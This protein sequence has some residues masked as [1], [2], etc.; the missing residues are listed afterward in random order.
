MPQKST[1]SLSPIDKK[2]AIL[3]AVI[4]SAY[5][6]PPLIIIFLIAEFGVN[7]PHWDQWALV[8]LFLKIK[9][10]SVSF[11]DFFAQHNEHRM[12]FSRIIIV[13]LAF[14]SNWNNK[15]EMYFGLFLGVITF[16]I[17]YLISLKSISFGKSQNLS[18]FHLGNILTCFIFFSTSQLENYLW[19]F[20]IAWFLVNFC[21]IAA[22][23]CLVLPSGKRYGY[24]VFYAGLLC[25]IASFTHGQGLLTWIALLPLLAFS[26][27]SLRKRTIV[28]ALWITAFLTTFFIYRIGYIT[29]EHHAELS[30]NSQNFTASFKYFLTLL[31][32][33]FS[34][35]ASPIFLTGLFLLS[36]FLIFN[37][38]FL[39]NPYSFSSQLICPWLPLGWF[40]ILFTII[41]TSGRAGLGV[42][43][44]ASS[45]YV[46]VTMLLMIALI[47]MGRIFL[48]FDKRRNFGPL[49]GA[50]G[51]GA[52]LSIQL[53]TTSQHIH[54]LKTSF[55]IKE[56][57]KIC[58]ELSRFLL[59]VQPND[60]FIKCISIAVPD[61]NYVFQNFD[62]LEN[63]GF[64][65][66]P[67]PDEITFE[68]D[69]DALEGYIDSPEDSNDPIVISNEQGPLVITGWSVLSNHK[70]S[71]SV[72]ILSFKSDG[73]NDTTLLAPKTVIRQP[74]PDVV[75]V[76][77][78]DKVLQS[79]WQ[80][81]I[82]PQVIPQG[83][84]VLKIWVYE[85]ES[86]RFLGLPETLRINKVS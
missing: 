13:I 56:E 9:D 79:G 5:C 27:H 11:Q 23:A 31:G 54:Y 70:R 6:L 62:A 61:P 52:L 53:M 26:Q 69:P 16:P 36:S 49:L 74:R 83:E 47:Q 46:T 10:S 18:L 66:F 40:A 48:S 4:I 42:N 43:Q 8:D 29:P 22:I 77:R 44:A 33:I 68:E 19:G 85:P 55:D 81:G 30:S 64:F 51:A 21:L 82:D 84:G 72:M 12:F 67:G 17:L 28:L 58:L 20:Q 34:S 24:Q 32:S 35:S 45:R 2:G 59:T 73:G 37:I 15:L 7:V 3:H 75:N 65:D 14:L 63:L 60:A 1:E 25:F 41:T 80:L 76:L 39:R 57:S 78:S 50:F 38:L 71:P 86:K